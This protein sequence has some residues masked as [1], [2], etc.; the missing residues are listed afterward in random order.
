MNGDE[1][2]YL[3][4]KFI[5]LNT[6][7]NERWNAHDKSSTERWERLDKASDIISSKVELLFKE[8]SKVAVSDEKISSLETQL[9]VLKNNDLHSI[10][11]KIN[12]LLYTVLA[13]VFSCILL[14][15]IRGFISI[16]TTVSP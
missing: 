8:I 4:N 12:A 6:K 13:T 11:K 15:G 2:K 9:N 5:E 14:F 7:F 3:N 1:T 16:I 10:N